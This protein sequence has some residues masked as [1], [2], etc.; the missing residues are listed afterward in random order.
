LGQATEHIPGDSFLLSNLSLAL[1]EQGDYVGALDRVSAAI[2]ADP[3]QPSN[4][5]HR[6]GLLC[7][8]QRGEEAADSLRTAPEGI[9][10][11]LAADPATFQ[12]GSALVRFCGPQTSTLRVAL[13]MDQ[14]AQDAAPTGIAEFNFTVLFFHISSESQRPAAQ[15]LQQVMEAQGYRVA[16]IRLITT[17]YRSSVRYYYD[18]Q[19]D[20]A[21]QVAEALLA[22][23]PAAQMQ[24]GRENLVLIPLQDRYPNLPRDRA[25]V[26]F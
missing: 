2:T 4:Y 22:A 12:Q 1:A 14:A 7:A 13:G 5:L 10:S 16:S 9:V 15:A 3:G 19:H 26:W 6:A 24:L 20:Q 8:L 25:E 11:A 18:I 21:E 17:P 23:A